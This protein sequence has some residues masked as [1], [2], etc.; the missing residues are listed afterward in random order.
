MESPGVRHAIGALDAHGVV[1][2][3]SGIKGV[4]GAGSEKEYSAGGSLTGSLTHQSGDTSLQQQRQQQQHHQQH[5]QQGRQQ[6]I[7]AG[8]DTPSKKVGQCPSMSRSLVAPLSVSGSTK[9]N[10]L[11]GS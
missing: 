3:A 7:S 2:I 5:Q 4:V 6:R 10:K 1:G 11:V 9:I 8:P